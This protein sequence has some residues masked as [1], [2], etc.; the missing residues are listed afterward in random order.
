MVKIYSDADYECVAKQKKRIRIGFW[1]S[2]ALLL[3]I[4]IAVFVLYT[5]QEFDT[6]YKSGMLAFNIISDALFAIICYPVL[7]IRLKRVNCYSKMLK[8]FKN[9]IKREGI[10]TFVRVD[11][12][13]TVKDGVEFIN[14][15]FLE[16]S[17]KKQSYFES[18][19]LFDPEKPVP[20]F[21]AGDT[22]HHI[23]QA[24]ILLEYELNSQDI[25]E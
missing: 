22:V 18:N 12:S 24:N 19:I 25:F 20:A 2:L 23:T 9:G 21:A 8:A 5:F 14:L 4:N 6:P 1:V 17:D 13:V 16:W 15:V 7:A 11:S 3:A 10:N